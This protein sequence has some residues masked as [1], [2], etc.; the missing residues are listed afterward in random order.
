MG[1]KKLSE[2]RTASEFVKYAERAGAEIQGGGKHIKVKTETGQTVVPNGR[3]ELGRGLRSV[4]IKQF[5]ALGLAIMF[6]CM[7]FSQLYL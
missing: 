5:I 4:I 2:C 7:I 3:R 1:K 6:A